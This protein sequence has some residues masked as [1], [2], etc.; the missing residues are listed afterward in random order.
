MT[1]ID[2]AAGGD[3]VV[4]GGF[5]EFHQHFWHYQ[6]RKSPE[7]RAWAFWRRT[8]EWKLHDLRRQ[9]VEWVLSK[10]GNETTY[11]KFVPAP[12]G[13]PADGTFYLKQ[14]HLVTLAEMFRFGTQLC[15]CFDI[16]R[17]FVHLPIFVFKRAHS[18]SGSEPG[19]KRRQAKWLRHEETGRY[20][21]P[22][23]ANR[24]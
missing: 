13:S 9:D 16:Y 19:Q 1:L 14:G 20:G 3:Q 21:L 8:S 22:T 7:T 18:S 12:G 17:T 15:T 4:P 24:W 11:V 2:P 5:T 10:E 6:Y 23:R